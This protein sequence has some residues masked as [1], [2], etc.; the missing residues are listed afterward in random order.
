MSFTLL[1][2]PVA[3]EMNL[4]MISIWLAKLWS[5]AHVLA[6]RGAEYLAIS[7]S[8]REAFLS[9]FMQ[10]EI[11]SLNIRKGFWNWALKKKKKKEEDKY[12]LPLPNSEGNYDLLS[13]RYP[14]T[15]KSIP[16]IKLE[17]SRETDRTFGFLLLKEEKVMHSIPLFI[18][19]CWKLRANV[20]SQ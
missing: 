6:A 20:Q 11:N 12:P 18:L 17:C 15:P 14:A 2:G 4:Y 8:L 5:H 7:A 10:W 19:I 1:A 16:Y 3:L 13:I 9:K